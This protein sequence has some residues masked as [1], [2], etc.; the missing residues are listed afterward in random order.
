MGNTKVVVGAGK[1]AGAGASSITVNN[2]EFA[3]HCRRE[4]DIMEAMHAKEEDEAIRK[5]KLRKLERSKKLQFEAT[6]D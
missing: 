4:R 3:S 2:T 6:V 5:R 1:A